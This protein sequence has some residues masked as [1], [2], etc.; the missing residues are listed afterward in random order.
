ML[1]RA[2]VD[3]LRAAVDAAVVGLRIAVGATAVLAVPGALSGLRVGR[4]SRRA[5]VEGV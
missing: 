1:G 4:R 3:R 5:R 2:A